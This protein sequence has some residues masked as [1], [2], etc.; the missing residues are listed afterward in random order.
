MIA[1]ASAPNQ[2]KPETVTARCA[3]TE[4]AVGPFGGPMVHAEA[5]ALKPS[6]GFNDCRSVRKNQE[7]AWAG[8]LCL[9]RGRGMA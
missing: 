3:N 7:R 5:P 1:L 8:R 9:Q 2:W 6:H 4:P